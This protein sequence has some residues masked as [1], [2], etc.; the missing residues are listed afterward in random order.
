MNF[1][2]HL[3][4]AQ[5]TADSYFGNLLGDFRRGVDVSTYPQAV[6][7][8]V[9][10][11]VHVDR[12]T[13]NHPFVKTAKKRVSARRRRY[14]GIMLDILFDHFLIKHWQHYSQQSLNNFCCD[15][16]HRLDSRLHVMPQRMQAVVNSMLKYRW[17]TT[18]NHL[19]GVDKALDRTAER[20]RFR[21]SFH[22]SI[23]EVHAHYAEFEE[24][25]M[26]FFPELIE[27]VRTHNIESE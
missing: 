9:A 17:L 10:N 3:F 13:D 21:H 16:Y 20:I 23:E 6:Q 22:G 27:S 18:Y 25:F 24:V 7:S 8:G 14:A 19:N 1:L 12:F 2:A 4:L 5:P 26:A 11:H 15:A